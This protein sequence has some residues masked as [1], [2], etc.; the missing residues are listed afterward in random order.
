MEAGPARTFSQRPDRPGIGIR[1]K[2]V[3]FVSLKDGIDTST[4][5]GRFTFNIFGS[6]A[7]FEREILE[8]LQW[9]GWKLPAPE[10]ERVVGHQV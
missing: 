10:E 1:E 8:N 9:L 6:L 7:E 3:E 5:T 4:A 2:G